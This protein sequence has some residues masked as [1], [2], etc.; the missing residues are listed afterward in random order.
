MQGIEGISDS[1][2]ISNQIKDSAKMIGVKE[3]GKEKLPCGDISGYEII[4]VE[5][6]ADVMNLLRNGIDNVIAMN[7]TK[8]PES[9]GELG[10][11]KEITLFVDGD[12]GGKLII[13][14]VLDNA[15]VAYI[16]FAPD[17]K[18]VEEL[19]G[20]EILMN[21]RKRIP[22][23]DYST[24]S[25]NFSREIK[26]QEAL[27]LNKEQKETLRK[28]SNEI[29]GTGKAIFLNENLEEIKESSSRGIGITLKK[30][31]VTPTIIVMDG[32][33]TSSVTSA[34]EEAGVRVIVAKSFATSDTTI[35]LLSL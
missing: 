33:V 1:R 32:I 3:Y 5:G 9:I 35:K 28:I 34:A 7:G 21:L 17:G 30:V 8:L 23:K 16:A 15:K 2:E 4:V 26:P 31:S 24:R 6:R 20:K 27:E 22:V 11:E 19:T 13:Q 25:Y 18:E 29:Q 14:N 12:R 10:K